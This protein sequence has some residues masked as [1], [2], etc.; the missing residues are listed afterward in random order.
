MF[1]SFNFRSFFA[2]QLGLLVYTVEI[3]CIIMYLK[4]FKFREQQ[5]PIFARILISYLCFGS[6][7]KKV[8]CVY[9]YSK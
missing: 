8:I 1:S 3:Y 6:L 9:S 7:P 4:C 2:L 5:Q